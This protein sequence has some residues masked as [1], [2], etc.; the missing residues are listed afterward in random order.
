MGHAGGV[1]QGGVTSRSITPTYS[2][3]LIYPRPPICNANHSLPKPN[4][5]PAQKAAEGTTDVSTVPTPAPSLSSLYL[6]PSKDAATAPTAKTSFYSPSKLPPMP[7]SGLK[8]EWT[9]STEKVERPA[10]SYF[11]MVSELWR[12]SGTRRVR[13]QDGLDSDAATLLPDGTFL[14]SQDNYSSRVVKQTG[15]WDHETARTGQPSSPAA[16]KA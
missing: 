13:Q 15:T 4:N 12:G 1:C 11:P 8:L 2:S 9:P 10:Y 5:A 16:G 14:V 3:L 6:A 7:V